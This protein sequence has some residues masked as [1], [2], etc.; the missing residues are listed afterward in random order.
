MIIAFAH[1]WHYCLRPWHYGVE[2]GYDETNYIECAKRL[3]D[4]G[5]FSFW[6]NGPDA[7]VTPGFVLWLAA[8]MSVFG[9]GSAAVYAVKLA[10]AILTAADVFLT[11]DIGRKLTRGRLAP[12]TGAFFVAFSG[13]FCY[14]ARFML[15]E[16]LYH[17]LMLLSADLIL[18]AVRFGDRK[19]SLLRF[20]L[21]GI[22][23][24]VC[25]EVRSPIAVVLPFALVLVLSIRDAQRR[26]WAV[27]AFGMLMLGVLV[28]VIPWTF[29]NLIVLHKFVP[30]CTQTNAFF[31]GF[32]P[33]P[34]AL[35]LK[36]PGSIWGNLR[37]VAEF[38]RADPA[39]MLKYM[40]VT[41]FR[42]IFLLPD[43]LVFPR[44][45]MVNEHFRN[46]FVYAGGAGILA[47]L[48]FRRYRRISLLIIFFIAM[49]FLVVPVA[50]YGVQF[51][52]FFGLAAGLLAE[53]ILGVFKKQ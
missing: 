35:G 21:C 15:T 17:F 40:T 8:F 33:D 28:P 7:Y 29:R 31:Y 10:Q 43:E 50:R 42:I 44:L 53:G 12:L 14:Y 5:S 11:W 24:G 48:F 32:T 34:L 3:L 38:F 25:I 49:T 20:F 51:Y 47:G 30:F 13:T 18:G 6:G 46:L 39:G 16:P 2:F 52:P 37:Y 26:K 19:G 36:D 27:R 9:K 4:T 23:A 45:Y 22:V 41:K 1:S